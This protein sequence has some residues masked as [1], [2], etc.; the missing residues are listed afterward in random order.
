MNPNFQWL[1]PWL[2]VAAAILTVIVGYRFFIR[3]LGMVI[4]PNN[5]VGIVTKKFGL[6]GRSA[7]LPDGKIIALE[8]K[9]AFK[10]TR[11]LRDSTFGCGLG[12][13]RCISFLS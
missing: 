1:T 4:V 2:V 11:W 3:I 10:R 8:A 12:N 5:A 7:N 9:Q 6:G 13:T